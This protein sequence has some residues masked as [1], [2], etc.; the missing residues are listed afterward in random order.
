MLLAIDTATRTISLALHDGQSLAA[1]SSWRSPN[2][3][4]VELAPAVMQMLDRAGV[5]P[6]RLRGIGVALGPGSFTGL[7]IGLAL[8]KG[9][10]LAHNLPLAGIPTLDILAQAQPLRD[11]PML[12]VLQA[13]RGRVAVGR[14]VADR[15][16][17][18]VEGQV[19]LF[20]WPELAESIQEPVYVCGEF[21]EE[22][23]ALFRKMRGR[24]ILAPGSLSLRRAGVL[25][26]LAWAKLRAGQPDD[27][28]TLAPIYLH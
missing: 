10:A 20:R 18:R 25:A 4:T 15:K 14:Y 23:L 13:G 17:W 21:D 1:E 24:A 2:H 28:A 26:E 12:A 16:G 7:R 22:G 9:M 19:Q 11:G 8:A 3:H 5:T 27:A 6:A